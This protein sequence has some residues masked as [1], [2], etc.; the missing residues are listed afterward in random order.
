[1]P[2]PEWTRDSSKTIKEV[3]KSVLVIGGGAIGSE[4]G[5]ALRHYGADVTVVEEA[6]H[7]LGR[8]SADA[9]RYLQAQ[10]KVDG[11]ALHL[12]RRVTRVERTDTGRTATLNDGARL[13][14]EHVLVA[15]GRH[16]RVDGPGLKKIGIQSSKQGIACDEHCRAAEDVWAAGDVTGRAMYTHVASYQAR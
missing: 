8:E 4:L 9:A 10:F 12:G 11:I 14:A 13:S 7:L 2:D 1:M 6:D 3:P 5:Q 15:T 16:A